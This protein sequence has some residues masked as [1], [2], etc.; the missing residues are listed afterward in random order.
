[1]TFGKLGA[2]GSMDKRYMGEGVP[3][4]IMGKGLDGVMIIANWVAGMEASRIMVPAIRPEAIALLTLAGCVAALLL[5]KARIAAIPILVLTLATGFFEPAPLPKINKTGHAMVSNTAGDNAGEVLQIWFNIDADPVETDPFAHANPKRSDLILNGAAIWCS[6]LF[7]TS[8]P[9][10]HTIFTT[11]ATNVELLKRRD[12]PAFKACNKELGATQMPVHQLLRMGRGAVI[13]LETL[14]NE[15]VKVLANGKQIAE[16]EVVVS[17][18]SID[19]RGVVETALKTSELRVARERRNAMEAADDALW[20]T[21]QTTG[22][23]PTEQMRA[24]YDRAV[25]AA[26]ALGFAYKTLE[27]IA[28][29]PTADLVS[30]IEA[31]EGRVTP[32]EAAAEPALDALLGGA[33]EPQD[34]IR[35]ALEEYFQVEGPIE[36]KGKSPKQ[37]ESWKKVK[38]RAVNNFITLRGN[39]AMVSID[40]VDGLAIY[41]WWA[42][43]VSGEADGKKLSGSSANRDIGNLRKLYRE[44]FARRGIQ[45]LNPFDGLSYAT[46]KSLQ[47]EVPPFPTDWIEKKFL[48]PEAWLGLNPQAAL[49]FLSLIETG[50]RPSEVCN[51]Q[52]F[53]IVL[54]HEIPHIDIRPRDDRAIKTEGSARRIPLVGVSLEAMQAAPKGFPQYH[55]K[56]DSL[57]AT[58]LKHLRRRGLM[59]SEN[60][61][62]YSIRHSFDDRTLEAKIDRDLRARLMGHAVDRPDYGE[63]GS[64]EFRRDQ[65]LKI[66]LPYPGSLIPSIASRIR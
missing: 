39:K 22:K 46:P 1:M 24:V 4:Q 21:M 27:D 65:L 51:L 40:R 12:D 9:D 57:S 52:P 44:Y 47:Q 54:D 66:A 35:E 8:D 53:Q 37:I 29:G 36:N 43:R 10:T 50:C 6:A 5:G 32:E 62:I 60:H 42:K 2:I 17:V 64:L 3:L 30:R 15:H 25:D 28:T 11:F 61:I 26:K 16:A 55:D 7:R 63:G 20:A 48:V 58:L 18:A 34:T 59:P 19:P 33:E 38:R 41:D 31:L 56:E 13:E 23:P 49:I 14:P 45:R